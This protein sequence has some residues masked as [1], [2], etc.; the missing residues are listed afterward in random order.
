MKTEEKYIA[1]F[2]GL[3][4]AIRRHVEQKRYPAMG[5][6]TN[7]DL[8]CDF[9]VEK[10]NGLIAK[11]LPKLKLSELK[12]AALIKNDRR[13]TLHYRLFLREWNRRRSRPERPKL[14]EWDF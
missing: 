7:F 3:D 5:Y 14:N 1:A 6:T 11:L 12:P 9:Q 4:M 13:V 2:E 8:I 10:L